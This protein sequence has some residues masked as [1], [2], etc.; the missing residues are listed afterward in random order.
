MTGEAI[1]QQSHCK[2]YSHDIVQSQ[3]VVEVILVNRWQ[4]ISQ[5]IEDKEHNDK[6]ADIVLPFESILIFCQIDND[7]VRPVP[8]DS[9]LDDQGETIGPA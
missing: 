7:N 5:E 6:D 1:R 2:S 3:E 9:Q 8:E 4:I